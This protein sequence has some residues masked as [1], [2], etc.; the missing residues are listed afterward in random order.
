MKD[1]IK[2]LIKLL[3]MKLFRN[4]FLEK[5]ISK[6]FGLTFFKRSFDLLV[7]YSIM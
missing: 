5:V 7:L 2:D 3:L 6:F 1:I 4:T